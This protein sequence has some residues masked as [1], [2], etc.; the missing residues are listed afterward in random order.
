MDKI[1]VNL[2]V[3]DQKLNNEHLSLKFILSNNLSTL[4]TNKTEQEE[5]YM[6]MQV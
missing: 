2:I 1:I 6:Y 5:K 3:E 4:N